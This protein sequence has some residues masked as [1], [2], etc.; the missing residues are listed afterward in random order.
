MIFRKQIWPLILLGLVV[1]F[2]AGCAGTGGQRSKTLSRETTPAPDFPLYNTSKILEKILP[3]V[4]HLNVL[5][6]Y[7]VYEFNWESKVSQLDV[8]GKTFEQK[9]VAKSYIHRPSSG[10]ATVIY[11]DNRKLA[12]ITCA[13]IVAFPDTVLQYFYDENG[14]RTAFLQRIWV[15]RKQENFLVGVAATE[16][17]QILAID[18]KTDLAV[19]GTPL[20]AHPVPLNVIN[21]SPGR[22]A[23][24]KWGSFV[25]LIGFPK[26]FKMVIHGLASHR[27]YGKLHEFLVDAPF[28]RGF[29]GGL[30]LAVQDAGKQ[31]EWVG[32]ANSSAAEEEYDLS[33]ADIDKT[34]L[35]DVPIPYSGPVKISPRRRINYGITFGI[36]GE[37]IR[38][39]LAENQPSLEKAGFRREVFFQPRP[40]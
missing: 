34:G 5:A 26:G 27:E 3:S 13:H 40:E 33:P 8:H 37:L 1:S 35:S 7:Q 6:F 19:V 21:L 17:L 36:S 9:A 2:L 29:S 32:L 18:V 15:K 16:Q 20:L 14:A 4:V 39:F 28:N 30:V 23:D 11:N 24:L 31:L 10:T 12:L 22:A 25:Y 38:Q